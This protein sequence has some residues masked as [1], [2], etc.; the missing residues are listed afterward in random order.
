MAEVG[1]AVIVYDEHRKR[2]D[3]LITAIHGW[4]T[5]EQRD[6][7]IANTV[8]GYETQMAEAESDE[9]KARIQEWIDGSK[10]TLEIP[11]S[12]SAINAVYLSSDESKSDPY[13]RQVERLSSLQHKSGTTNMVNPG[14]YYV[15]V[16]EDE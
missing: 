16:G 3:G 13:G 8:A 1:D 14:R 11:F 10:R 7:Q 2:H 6:Q 9:G 15:L 12:P 4:T 5:K